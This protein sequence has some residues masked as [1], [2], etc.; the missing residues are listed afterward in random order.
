MEPFEINKTATREPLWRLGEILVQRGWIQWPE[1]E[2]ALELQKNNNRPIGEI[3]LHQ[4]VISQDTLF[5][6][7]AIQFGKQFVKIKNLRPQTSAI[8]MIPKHFVYE[9]RVMPLVFNEGQ[10]LV[11]INDPLDMWPMSILEKI[12]GIRE[13][14]TV[15]ATPNDIQE[16]IENFYGPE[17]PS[18]LS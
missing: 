5:E 12:T 15:L 10:L 17:G 9:H 1:L 8:K 4:G 7:L 16:A 14:E 2:T 11:A 13:I 6:A 3:L 18:I